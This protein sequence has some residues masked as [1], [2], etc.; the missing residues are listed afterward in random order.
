MIILRRR[1]KR[2]EDL[3]EAKIALAESK[4][5]LQRTQERGRE[6]DEVVEELRALRRRNH[7]AERLRPTMGGHT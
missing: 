4:N 3:E 1:R 7:F 2:K 5:Q 6:V